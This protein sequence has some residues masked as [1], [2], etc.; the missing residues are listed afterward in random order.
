MNEAELHVQRLMRKAEWH[1]KRAETLETLAENI[2]VK[3]GI[4]IDENPTKKGSWVFGTLVK[5]P[6]P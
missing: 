4:K 2:A 3:H 1:R 5:E 6:K